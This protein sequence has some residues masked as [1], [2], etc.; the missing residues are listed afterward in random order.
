MAV[1]GSRTGAEPAASA[2]AAFP[3]PSPIGCQTVFSSRNFEIVHGLCS[4]GGAVD[5]ALDV[6]GREPLELG[7][8]AVRAGQVDRVHV[9]VPGEDRR[10]L[11]LAAR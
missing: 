8:G 6:V 11:V 10:Q 7:G 4:S 2:A 9:H 1:D 5:D 3:L